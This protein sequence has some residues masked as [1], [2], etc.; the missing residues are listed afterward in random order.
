MRI[1]YSSRPPIPEM[2]PN[3]GHLDNYRR[4]YS[5]SEKQ[6]SSEKGDDALADYLA[7]YDRLGIDRVVIKA[8]DVETTFGFKLSN[9]VVAAFCQQ[10]GPRFVGFAGVDPHKGMSALRELEHAVKE[11]GLIGL[12]LQCFEHRLPINDKKMYPLYAKC[13]ELDIPV[14]IH[15]G[16]NFSIKSL[17]EYGRPALLDE[18]M[19][20]FPE[21][22]VCASPVGWPWVQELL[23][24]AWRHKNVMIGIVALRPKYLKVPD[25]GYESILRYG[26]SVLKQQIMVGTSYPM[27]PIERSID[28]FSELTMSEDI[29]KLWMGENARRFLKI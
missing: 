14:N 24:V 9:E 28:E 11:L 18:V 20:D 29:R 13:I 7:A 12:N 23:A 25:N 1:D 5:A 8:R 17:M 3:L 6:V 27:M 19:V 10:H 22:K 21:L 16:T 2:N 4:V 26:R 15:T